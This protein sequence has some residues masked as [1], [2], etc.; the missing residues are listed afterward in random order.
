VADFQEKLLSVLRHCRE[1]REMLA[2]HLWDD[3]PTIFI[4]GYVLGIGKESFTLEDIDSAAVAASIS[5][6]E[7]SRVV[8]FHIGSA[9]LRRVDT[10]YR[11]RA[12]IYQPIEPLGQF[13]QGV[14]FADTL[15]MALQRRWIVTLKDY[16]KQTLT[17]F[18]TEVGEDFVGIEVIVED[19]QADGVFAV[20]LDDIAFLS[21][22]GRDEQALAYLHQ[23]L[24]GR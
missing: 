21:V 11:N 22:N 10:L 13:G 7:L 2:V 19:G 24:L 16:K 8:R 4:V 6:I 20:G 18:V 12:E 17:G 14:L 9:Y 3:D 5:E 15:R 1:H 23:K